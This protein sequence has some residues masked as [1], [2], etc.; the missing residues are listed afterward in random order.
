[1]TSPSI[2]RALAARWEKAFMD[3]MSALNVLPPSTLTRV[4]EYVPEIVSF[5]ERVV[6]RGF[7]YSD[8]EG[9]VWFDVKAFDGHKS[10]GQ[11]WE[12]TYAKLAPWSKGNTRLLEEGEGASYP[13]RLSSCL[14]VAH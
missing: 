8:G 13:S 9:G 2:S 11:A 5:V 3:D 10:E 6:E 14:R 1:V 12:H 7:A 4:S